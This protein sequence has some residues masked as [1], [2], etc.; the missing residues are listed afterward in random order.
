MDY[1]SMFQ[2]Y[3]MNLLITNSGFDRAAGWFG[4]CDRIV[5]KENT[6]DERVD[7]TQYENV[8]FVF[9][10]N[11]YLYDNMDPCEEI[12][13]LMQDPYRLEDALY[14]GCVMKDQLWFVF[15]TSNQKF[16]GIYDWQWSP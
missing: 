10:P 5:F 11:E 2:S 9:C 6:D 8:S 15:D 7:F 4:S 12:E 14:S 16:I 3:D 1:L 13:T